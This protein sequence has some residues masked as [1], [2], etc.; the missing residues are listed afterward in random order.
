MRRP[1]AWM[2][3]VTVLGSLFLLGCGDDDAEE[4]GADT[5]EEAEVTDES[6]TSDAPESTDA[7][8]GGE[9]ATGPVPTEEEITTCLEDLDHS[10]TDSVGSF[11]SDTALQVN[12][13]PIEVDGAELYVYATEADAVEHVPDIEAAYT[14]TEVT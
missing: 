9:T 13:G 11:G 5:S 6:A 4:T 8:D 12:G 3:G 7:S 14:V 2:A 10:V 1:T